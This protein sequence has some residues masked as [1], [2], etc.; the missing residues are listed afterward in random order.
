MSAVIVVAGEALVDLVID[1]DGSVVS[2]LGGAPYN[3]ARAAARLGASVAF[4]GPLSADR[5]GG[6][7]AALLEAD[8]VSIGGAPRTNLP[9]T[10][11]TAELDRSGSATYRFYFDGTSAPSLSVDD[12]ARATAG[13]AAGDVFFTGGLGLVLEPMA[14]SIASH[15]AA[16]DGSEMVVV[17][18][19]A[20]PAVIGDRTAYLERLAAVCS[21]ADLVKVSDEDLDFLAPDM[22]VESLLAGGTSAVVVTAGSSPTLVVHAGGCRSVPVAPLTAPIVDTIGAGDTFI[23]A[24]MAAWTTS[25]LGRA[26]V[27]ALDGADRLVA[28]V[29]FASRAAAVVVTRHGADPP[30]SADLA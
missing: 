23:G 29:E 14:S 10:L 25:G 16:M 11:A 22:T 13:A 26:D 5:F 9:T 4:A 28:A 6:L 8:N 1:L 21:R 24:L 27:A 2:A 30:T 15:I 17:D 19:N 12:L 7:L 20:R 3:A 18:V